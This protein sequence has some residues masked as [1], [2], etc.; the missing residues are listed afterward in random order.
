M[1]TE[2][3]RR[4]PTATHKVIL[5]RNKSEVLTKGLAGPPPGHIDVWPRALTPIGAA[6]T[7]FIHTYLTYS[8][9]HAKLVASGLRVH[10][11][12]QIVELF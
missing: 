12:V 6:C 1:H 8:A 7:D 5:R 2:R 11:S 9:K 3:I 4:T 10:G